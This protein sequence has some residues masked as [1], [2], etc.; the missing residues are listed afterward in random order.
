MSSIASLTLL[1]IFLIF[2]TNAL[3]TKIAEDLDPEDLLF[4]NGKSLAISLSRIYK[5]LA[6]WIRIYGEQ[7]QPRGVQKNKRPL[8]NQLVKYQQEFKAAHPNISSMGTLST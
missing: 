5:I 1:R 4:D 8:R 7:H 6:I 3:V 2:V